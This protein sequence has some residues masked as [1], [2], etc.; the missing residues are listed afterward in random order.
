M[1]F[2]SLGVLKALV[3]RVWRVNLK[4]EDG[5]GLPNTLPFP[6]PL[7]SIL[8]AAAHCIN[9]FVPSVQEGHESMTAFWKLLE[10][11]ST[12]VLATICFDNGLHFG[13]K[14]MHLIDILIAMIC[15]GVAR[16]RRILT[17]SR[18][19][20]IPHFAPKYY[21]RRGLMIPI[22]RPAE[23]QSHRLH[24]LSHHGKPLQTLLYLH[25]ALIVCPCCYSSVSESNRFIS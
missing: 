22:S 9:Q 6:R 18:K 19:R 4:L 17:Q 24:S 5:N 3:R 15:C 2:R 8:R 7:R 11:F 12:E 14:K 1:H 16:L 21:F 10:R 20:M 13:G 25:N 23:H